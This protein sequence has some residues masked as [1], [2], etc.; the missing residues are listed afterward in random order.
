MLVFGL[1]KSFRGGEILDGHCEECGRAELIGVRG[2]RYFHLFWLPV[3]PLGSTHAVV[4]GHC[5]HTQLGKEISQAHKAAAKVANDSVNRPIWHF[6][7]PVLLTLI[8]VMAEMESQNLEVIE[9]QAAATP[10]AGDV[11]IINTEEALPDEAVPYPYGAA[12]VKSTY[13]D[14]VE[15][16]FSDW[17]Y[18]TRSSARKA[19]KEALAKEQAYFAYQVWIKQSEFVALQQADH[20]QLVDI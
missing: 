16:E 13:A 1:D 14:S 9:T 19:V 3:I 12:I 8:I 2:F 10:T 5:Q 17:Y 4:C 18:G 11:W 20:I 6:I 15:L 7:G